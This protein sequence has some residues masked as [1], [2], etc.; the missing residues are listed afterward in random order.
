VSR[1]QAI[2]RQAQR[3]LERRPVHYER[4]RLEQT[5]RYR[6]VPLLAPEQSLEPVRE[7]T[8]HL[9]LSNA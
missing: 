4:H 6:L 8:L 9:S 1:L 3:A 5:T 7:R 2:G